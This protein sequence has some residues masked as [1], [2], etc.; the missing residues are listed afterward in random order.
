MKFIRSEQALPIAIIA[1]FCA[2]HVPLL[3]LPFFWDEAGYYIPAASDLFLS[4]SLLPHSTLNT[5]HTPLLSAY[6]AL[7]WKVFGYGIVQTRVAM[8]AVACF[9][10]WQVYGLAEEIQNRTVAVATLVLTA[11]F[12]IIFAQSTMAHSDL[13]ATAL[14]WW[15]LREYFRRQRNAWRYAMAFTLA[16]LAKEIVVVV[17]CALALFEV[18]RS[19]TEGLRRAAVTPNAAETAT[20]MAVLLCAAPVGVLALW[21]TFQ[22]L[23]T[24]NWFGDPSYYQY[25][26]SATVEP[27][28]IVYAFAQRAWQG[29]GHMSMWVATLATAAAMLIP[30]KAGRDRIALPAQVAFAAVILA[31]L[32]FHSVLGGALLTRYLLVIYPLVLVICISTWWRR[33]PNWEW[34]AGLVAAMFALACVV[35]PPYRFA[36]EDNLNYASFVRVHQK[37]AEYLESRL[38]NAQVVTAWPASDELTKPELGYVERKLRVAS[39]DNFTLEQITELQATDFDVLFAFSTKFEPP[40]PLFELRWWLNVSRK[41][42]DYHRDLS[43]EDIAYMVSGRIVWQERQDGQWAAIIVRE[44]PHDARLMPERPA[45]IDLA[46]SRVR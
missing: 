5:A 4:G 13:L 9:G 11:A 2:A 7:M 21:F 18:L 12:P 26:V 24:G 35:N 30:A 23:S 42:F 20:K 40:L 43:A 22:R 44:L 36:P 6:L 1:I 46:N 28:R 27:L 3:R 32:L 38:A 10:L 34:L 8:L 39:I 41:Y 29:L 17:P 25:N 31:M 33:V 15:G 37:A 45:Q 19:R 14:A 16:V